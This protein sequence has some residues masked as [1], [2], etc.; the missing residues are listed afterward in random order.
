MAGSKSDRKNNAKFDIFSSSKEA[1]DSVRVGYIDPKRG[2]VSGLSVYKANKYA[3]RNPGTQFIIAN[4]DKIRYLNINEVNKLTNKD[5]LPAANP[6]GLVDENGEFDPCNT[7]KGFRT[8]P[9][10]ND[11]GRGAGG[12]PIIDP[13]WDPGEN[14]GVEK[15]P[16]L[17]VTTGGDPSGSYS[18]NGAAANYAKYGSE[19]EKC[20]VRVELQG[21]GGIGAVATPVVGLDG[22]ILH[23][24]VVHGGF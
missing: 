1:N 20:R 23:V 17:P 21:G 6:S 13:L 11:G 7:V 24:R 10:Q 8:D 4:R 19:L 9:D 22:A 14:G 18:G 3:E 12:E 5:T 2:Y 15:N 16:D